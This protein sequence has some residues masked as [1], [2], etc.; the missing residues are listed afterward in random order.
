MQIAGAP[1]AW[2]PPTVVET[3]SRFGD[4]LRASLLGTWRGTRET[5]PG[6]ALSG[7][8]I[9][10]FTEFL[11]PAYGLPTA[12]VADALRG[13]QVWVG[14]PAKG[15]GAAAVVLANRIYVPDAGW[16]R[17]I[18]SWDGRALMAHELGHVMQRLQPADRIAQ[19]LGGGELGRDRAAMAR[20]VAHMPGA[21]GAAARAWIGARLPGSGGGQAPPFKTLLHDLHRLEAEA[22]RH[23]IA[24]RDATA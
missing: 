19:L 7:A 24:F 21:A 23:A 11:A 3:R 6:Q 13:V 15:F 14:G 12:A 18:F 8:M 20:Y 17:H 2:T 22:E 10:T 1:P 16:L 4:D 9:A 5:A